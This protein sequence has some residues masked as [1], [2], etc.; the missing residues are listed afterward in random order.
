MLENFLSSYLKEIFFIYNNPDTREESFYPVLEKLLKSLLEYFNK[1]NAFVTLLPKKTEGGNPDFRIWDGNCHIIGYI[2]AK[3]PSVHLDAIENT[4]Q[5]LRYRNTFPNLILT[6]FIEFWLYRQGKLILKV[7]ITEPFVLEKL[8]IQPFLKNVKEFSN[9]FEVFVSFSLPKVFTSSELAKDLAKR[10]NILKEV[11]FEELTTNPTNSEISSFYE[12]FKK[13]LIS[14]LSPNEFADLYSQTV[15]YGLF[16]ARTRSNGNFTR[17]EAFYKIPQTIGILSHLFR[18]ISLGDLPKQMEWILDDIVNVLAVTDVKSLLKEYLIS[19]EGEDPIIHFYETFLSEYDPSTR[20]KR[21]VYYTPEPVVSFIVRSLDNLL[22]KEFDC[23]DGFSTSNVTLLDPAAGTLTFLAYATKLAVENYISSYGEGGNLRFIK[24][25]IL[26]NFYAFELMMAPYAV[27]HLKISLL[28]EELGYYMQDKERFKLYLTNTLDLTELPE[29]TLPGIKVLSEESHSASKI[30]NE[31]PILVI[32]GNPPYSGHS[33][34]TKPEMINFLKVNLDGLQSYYEVDGKPLGEKNPKWLQDDYVK[35]IR[36][37]QWK[38]QKAGRG[39]VGFITNHS[40]L[41]NPTFRG[42][43]QS[44][45]KTFNEI[46]I[47]NLHGN[48]LKQEK[49]P[50]NLKDENVFDIKQGV[51]ITIFVKRPIKKRKTKVYYY[52]LWGNRSKKYEFLKS[53]NISTIDWIELHPS[54][55]NYF[56][57]PTSIENKQKYQKFI[58]IT[59][60]FKE[61]NVGVVTARDKFTIRWTKDEVWTTVLNFTKLDIEMARKSYDLGKDARDWKVE[62]AQQDLLESGLTKENIVP[63]L[64]RPFDIRY[65]YYTGKSRGFHCMPRKEIMQ[66][67]LKI[68]DNLALI[69]IRRSRSSE[70]WNFSFVS[71]TIISGSTA[72][73]SLDINYIFPLYLYKETSTKNTKI[74]GKLSSWLL[75]EPKQ[76]Y[77]NKIPNLSENLLL[78]LSRNYNYQPLPEDIFYFIYAILYSDKYRQNY[79]ENL[80]LDFPKIPF[81][82]N[83][84]L[85]SKLVKLGK[86]LVSVHLL[87]SK[88][89]Y[90]SIAKLQGEGNNLIEKLEYKSNKLFINKQSYFEGINQQIW[91]YRFGGYKILEKWLNDRKDR[92]LTLDEIK[93]FCQI[94]TAIQKTMEIQWEIDKIY[95]NIEDELID[96]I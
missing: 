75:F 53:N 52:D 26:E 62:L 49:A 15:T 80:K 60:I 70:I 34:N 55:N 91:N 54:S 89:I 87:K 44:L 46:Y 33:A 48:S 18:F 64:Y 35:F 65:T 25:H 56:F 58:S 74:S 67:I 79:N 88:E 8:K 41:D 73:S 20:E 82:K 10:T 13:F 66:H 23:R 81:P 14:G 4:E 39:L 61:K 42:M 43:R 85:F 31:V 17:R 63:I 84:D 90:P 1:S 2:E 12:A 32:L 77:F 11:V 36:F 93:T 3:H 28:L 19:K 57:I 47:L 29:T 37:A 72:I 24:E 59:E 96:I 45:M 9:L 40:Y 50:N 92:Y 6:N 22:R 7:G 68:Q 86:R 78:L 51:A 76:D 30:K 95:D 27:G 16:I 69:T 83:K 38:I 71:E 94:V 5:L 21:G